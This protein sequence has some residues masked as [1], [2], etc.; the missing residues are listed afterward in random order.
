MA[1][2][3]AFRRKRTAKDRYIAL[4]LKQNLNTTQC[5][6]NMFKDVEKVW[7]MKSTEDDIRSMWCLGLHPTSNEATVNRL[8][9]KYADQFECE[10]SDDCIYYQGIEDTDWG[11]TLF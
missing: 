2:D 7:N 11:F 3:F 9:S 4:E 6:H 5:I 10:L 8:I 1:I